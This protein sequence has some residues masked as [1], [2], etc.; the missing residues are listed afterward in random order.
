L[1]LA[2]SAGSSSVA[3]AF[4]ADGFVEGTPARAK[5]GGKLFEVKPAGEEDI[6]ST[7]K[8][9]VVSAE[10]ALHEGEPAVGAACPAL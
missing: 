2:L 6:G 10:A 4:P 5:S 7:F 3:E 9:F 1:P 8:F